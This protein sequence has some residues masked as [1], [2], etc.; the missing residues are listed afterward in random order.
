M[1]LLKGV[2]VFN[3]A[4]SRR[5]STKL[6]GIQLS[7]RNRARR[8]TKKATTFPTSQ[9]EAFQ[10][11]TVSEHDDQ[12]LDWD[13]G[14]ESVGGDIEEPRRSSTHQKRKEKATE[15][16]N[17]LRGNLL[18][19]FRE[20]LVPPRSPSCSKCAEEASVRCTDCGVDVYF[21]EGCARRSH[22]EHFPYHLLE[23]WKVSPIL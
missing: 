4:R 16:W 14:S 17:T 21:C 6:V 19:A 11:S 13:D 2:G 9:P 3:S 15:Q 18:A 8:V 10:S 1:S 12:V 7:V 23:T 22:E 5:Q 20:Q